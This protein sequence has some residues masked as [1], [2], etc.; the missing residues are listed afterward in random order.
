MVFQVKQKDSKTE[1]ISI[2]WQYS[3]LYIINSW[4]IK[5]FIEKSMFHYTYKTQKV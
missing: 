4:K 2:N 3:K 1:I 5:R